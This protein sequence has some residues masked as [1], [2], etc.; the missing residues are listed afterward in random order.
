MRQNVRR[1]SLAPAME[2][3]P[4]KS[5]VPR[6]KGAVGGLNPMPVPFKM[7]SFVIFSAGLI[8][9]CGG[10]MAIYKSMSLSVY[11][12]LCLNRGGEIHQGF[13][14][15]LMEINKSGTQY[16]LRTAN[17]LFGEKTCDFLPVSCPHALM[18]KK[19]QI[20]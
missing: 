15:L 17:R 10:K 20:R 12:A 4:P 16:L 14:S 6:G 9:L 7:G 1:H 8:A 13:R 3:L 11:Q 19:W 5:T 18:L 2:C